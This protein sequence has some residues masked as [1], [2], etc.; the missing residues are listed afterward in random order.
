[1]NL[2]TPARVFEPNLQHAIRFV[3]MQ[4]MLNIHGGLGLDHETRQTQQQETR[5]D[6]VLLASG[7][8]GIMF[9]ALIS[10]RRPAGMVK[11]G[12]A[13]GI[14]VPEGHS[15]SP[16]LFQ[17]RLVGPTVGRSVHGRTIHGHI[18]IEVVGIEDRLGIPGLLRTQ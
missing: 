5:R 7:L 14:T 6:H 3:P 16:F 13:F 10:D 15:S 11:H 4:L 8:L 12:P 1:M 9:G 18:V 2:S 17:Q